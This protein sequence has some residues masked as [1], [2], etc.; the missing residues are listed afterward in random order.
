MNFPNLN[1]LMKISLGLIFFTILSTVFVYAETIS[2]NSS[3][4]IIKNAHSQDNISYLSNSFFSVTSGSSVTIVNND[5]V[6]HKFVSG[7]AN[8]EL[9]KS[10]NYDTYLLCEFGEK[11]APDTNKYSVDNMCNFNMDNRIITNEIFPGESLLVEINDI[12][13]YRLIDPD[14]PWIELLVYSFPD[15]E[16]SKNVNSGFPVDDT[17]SEQTPVEPRE[18]KPVNIIPAPLIQTISV[19]VNG[20]L[21]VVEYSVQGMT[22]TAIESDTESMSLIF[23]VDV[24]DLTGIMN[25]EFERTFFDSIY[26]GI[27]DPFWA[28]SDGEESTLEEIQTNLQ[29]RSLTIGVPLGSGELEIIGSVFNHS[30]EEPTTE[31]PTTEEPTTEEPTTEEPTTE[32][33]TTESMINNECGPGTVLEG[34][35]CIIDQRC[36]PGTVLEGDVCIIDQRC[37]PGTVLEGDVCVLVSTPVTSTSISKEL[38]MSVTIA[39]VI[40]GIVGIIFAL[41]AKVNK[42]RN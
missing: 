12:G 1:S 25:V 10:K 19:D 33:P 27:D 40:A 32:E 41:I 15:S 29:S 17:F 2:D 36:G 30:V 37:G 5:T 34:D 38:I 28:L 7:N 16:S 18:I 13:N 9:E 21:H 22:V 31:E 14:Y 24:T 3:V 39:F 26:D 20:I 6:S 4:D 11:I 42:N 23:F 8:S 35:V